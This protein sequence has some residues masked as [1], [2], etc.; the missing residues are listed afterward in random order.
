MDYSAVKGQASTC[1][2]SMQKSSASVRLSRLA[3]V[4]TNDCRSPCSSSVG[5]HLITAWTSS[6]VWKTAESK[7]SMAALTLRQGQL[8]IVL[9]IHSDNL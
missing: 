8:Q 5:R 6:A 1:M 2:R 4:L 9:R 3:P 7:A